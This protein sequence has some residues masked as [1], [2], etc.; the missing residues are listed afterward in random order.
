MDIRPLSLAGLKLVLPAVHRD[1][2]GFFL[3]T[4]NG[5]RYQQAGIDC[6][7]VQ[8][9]HSKSG[10]GTIRGMH[11]Q[12]SPG[13]AKLVR[14]AA[15]RIF[16][17]AVDIRPSSPTFGRWEGVYLDAAEHAQLFVPVG[18]A[19]GFCVVSDVAE[20]LY[21]VS[22][23]Y[24]ASTEAGFRYDDPE[25]GITWPVSHPKVSKRD[26]EAPTFAELRRSLGR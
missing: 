3:E 24:D 22:T 15:G 14:V 6:K 11:F 2:R 7:F 1:D 21:K 12:A 5:P 26:A 25:V 20:V 17:V 16:D 23:V 10:Q 4:Y 8:D 13:Q 9:N 18:F 19:H